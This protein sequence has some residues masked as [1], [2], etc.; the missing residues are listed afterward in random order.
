M[1]VD[2]GAEFEIILGGFKWTT[3]ICNGLQLDKSGFIRFVCLSGWI[4][5]R[6]SQAVLVMFIA[7]SVF[8]RKAE[9]EVCIHRQGGTARREELQC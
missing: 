1:Q 9:A 7:C 5:G 4:F 6:G 8:M 2:E 3:R